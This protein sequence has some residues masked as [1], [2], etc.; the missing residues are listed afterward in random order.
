M[1][2]FT[3]KTMR[4]KTDLHAML[5]D[6]AYW[7]VLFAIG[8]PVALQN[9]FS[10]GLNLI[11]SVMVGRLGDSSIAAVGI[12][13]TVFFLMILFM[14]GIASGIAIFIAQYWGKRDDEGVRM[15]MAIGVASAFFVAV[16]FMIASLLI[17]RQIMGFFTKDN[18]V[19]TLGADFLRI[20][21]LSYPLTAISN[22]FYCGL[23]SVK[24]A[25]LPLQVSAVSIVVNT[26]LNA[27]LIYGLAGF[28]RLGVKGSALATVIA[29][30]LEM[31][32]ILFF[33]YR[34]KYPVAF[35]FSDFLMIR[36]AFFKEIAR[37]TIPVML[38]EGLW[39]MG[40]SMYIVVF[41]KM[42]TSYIAGY[43]IM[44]VI[45]RIANAFVLG[46]AS[47]SA[48][49]VGHKIGE[50]NPKLAFT[51]AARNN[52]L[53]TFLGACIG[54]VLFVT[55]RD[56]AGLFNVSGQA[57]EA[58][59]LFIRMLA[60]IIP[61]KSFNCEN[62]LGALRAGGDTKFAFFLEIIPLWLIAV[63]LTMMAGWYWMWSLPFVY[64]LT[65][66]D[67]IIKAVFGF[68]RFVSKKWINEMR[69]SREL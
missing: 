35:R 18:T 26:V 22:V 52:L 11:D 32:L 47:A 37:V 50:G 19:I 24:I 53:G 5:H 46:I 40:I 2:F 38:N 62:F 33:V 54:V 60:F 45:D 13:N 25:K 61:F 57:R 3:D 29:R 8:I 56:I 17:P 27:L 59:I 44:Q 20:V 43:N 30:T 55:S 10:S 58:S 6:R 1:N 12:A 41:G 7:S 34:K 15:T 23:R 39:A 36:F 48:A 68:R 4:L 66:T 69:S 42:G 14:F 65:A 28:P 67:E 64:L 31:V 51:Y 63:P 49:L 16:L 21:S 9:L